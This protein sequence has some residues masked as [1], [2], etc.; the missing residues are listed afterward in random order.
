MSENTLSSRIALVTGGSR[1]L[2]RSAALWLA[3]GGAD[4]L[5]TYHS[6]ETAAEELIAQIGLLGH[7][8][9]A[10]KLDVG[11]SRSFDTF[12]ETVRHTLEM[13][14]GRS[15]FDFLVNN[16]GIGIH[17]TL[18]DTTE[19]Q[20][21]E[22]VNIHFKGPYFLTQKLLPLIEDGGRILNV[23]TG[24]TR[25]ASPGYSAYASMKG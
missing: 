21:D 23:S 24:L 16:A 5:F 10:F 12:A 3:R 8:A 4:V 15:R 18:A 19:A 11:D 6:N 9:V 20:F 25:F 17:A 2:G 7:K 1:G 13:H 14:W 22:L